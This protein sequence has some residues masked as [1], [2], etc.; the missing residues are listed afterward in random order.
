MHHTQYQTPPHKDRND[1]KNLMSLL[2][3]LWEYKGRVVL[4]LSCLIL[5]KLANVGIPLTLKAIVDQLDHQV[6]QLILPVTLLLGYGALKFSSSLFNEL[7]D[8]IFAKIRYR[9]MRRL[10]VKVIQ[11]LFSLSLRFHLERQ[12]GAISRDLERG[13]SSLS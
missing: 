4:A 12:T 9:A 7:R 13:T 3:L 11:H 6:E 1:L 5:A 2:P 8:A 10:S